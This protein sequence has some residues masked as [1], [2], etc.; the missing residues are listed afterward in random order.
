MPFHDRA[1]LTSAHGAGE[2]ADASTGK[3]DTLAADTLAGLKAK[4]PVVFSEP[5]FP[6]DRSDCPRVF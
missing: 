6:V 5:M 3:Y 2:D 4:Y 1:D